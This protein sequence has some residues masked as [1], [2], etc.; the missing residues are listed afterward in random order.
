MRAA[1]ITQF[2]EPQLGEFPEPEAGPDLLVLDV[3]AAAVNHV[4]L[5]R[6]TGRFYTGPPPLP[7]VVGS[8]GVGRRADGRLVYFDAPI[9]PFG[10]M[11]ERTLV[12][13]DSVIEVPD[14][15]DPRTAAALGNAGLAAH[16]GLRWRAGLR[17][18][19][20]VLVLGATGV[21]G[22]LAVQVARLLG[23]GRV[24]AAGRDPEGLARAAELGADATVA[25]GAVEDLP[26]ALAGAD[27]IVD[28]LWGEPALA[29]LAG[30]ASGVRMVQIG[31]LAGLEARVPAALVRSR[32]ADIRGHAVFQA[33]YEVRAAAYRELAH[34]A[35]R[36]DLRVAVQT[37]P[38]ADITAAWRR[39]SAG[40]RGV[41]QVVVP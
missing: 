21:V 41:K 34:A 5:M 36:G 4:D 37:V 16:T 32:A 20:T 31:Q 35:R 2:G 24:I 40:T 29:A 33:P 22:G 10:S 13:A 30:A 11:A 8:D 23:A 1:I 17:E 25:L 26:A 39:Q 6:A 3:M 19:E 14:G 7:S 12:R 18:G 38:L 9:A 28:L 15:V 27:V